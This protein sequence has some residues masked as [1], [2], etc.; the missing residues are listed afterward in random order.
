LAGYEWSQNKI[1]GRPDDIS[2][3]LSAETMEEALQKNNLPDFDIIL[4]DLLIPG[5]DPVENVK[6]L[7]EKFPGKPIVILTSEES[8][9]WK[10]QMFESGVHA[11]LTK[12]ESKKTITRTLKRVYKGENLAKEQ[13]TTEDVAKAEK[14]DEYIFNIILKPSERAILT[15]F[16]RELRMKEIADKT[17]MTETAVGKCMHKM[18]KLFGVKSNSGLMTKLI[19]KNILKKASYGHA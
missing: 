8:T 11:Y 6:R 2:I 1:Q 3:T 19:Q 18:R 5:T 15:L 17:F 13:L 4:L 14:D 12:H 7:K 9:A 16:S 10:M